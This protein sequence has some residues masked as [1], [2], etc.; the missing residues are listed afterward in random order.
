MEYIRSEKPPECV[1]CEVASADPAEDEE[2]RVVYRGRHHFV[3]LNLWP[4]NNGHSMVVPFRHVVD[5][6]ELTDDESLSMIHLSQHL[7]EAYRKTMNAEGVNVGLNLGRV[8][9]GSIDHLHQHL[10]PR[11]T[12]DANFMPVIGNTKVMV[13]MLEDTYARL[14]LEAKSWND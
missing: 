1:F 2:R 6:T 8:S 3:V 12:G 13:E 4:Y 7:V 5:L 11:W 9:G 10:V 14:I